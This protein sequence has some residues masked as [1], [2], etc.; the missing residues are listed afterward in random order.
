MSDELLPVLAQD[1]ELSVVSVDGQ[2]VVTARDLARALGYVREDA[3]RKI[4]NRN[5]ASF[6]ERKGGPNLTSPL[7]KRDPQF[8][9][10]FENSELKYD[11]GE[12]EIDTPG[13][14]Q[15]VRY[16]TKRGALKIC[17]KSNQPRAVA[18]QEMLIDLYEAVEGR[19][20]IPVEALQGVQ[21]RLDE[22]ATEVRRLVVAQ[23][24]KIVYLPRSC[25][26]RSTDNEAVEFFKLLFEENPGRKVSDA[27]RVVK[28]TANECGWR[29]G[30]D[31]A[32]YR[33]ARKLR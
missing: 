23:E 27:I 16:F 28:K 33:M 31:K 6:K 8:D 17:M 25:R 18:V 10:S 5:W 3:V 32:F 7:E 29:V 14:P 15:K 24:A 2:P 1:G 26:P 12:V 13:G 19:R 11:T 21:Q 30:S 4:L 9:T 20:M 22:L